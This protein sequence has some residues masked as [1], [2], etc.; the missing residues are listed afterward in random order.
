[1]CECRKDIEA[2]LLARFKEAAP[3]AADHKVDLQGYAFV[4][5]EANALEMRPYMTYKAGA[6]YPLKKGGTK[7]KQQTGNMMFNF[8]PFCGV[9]TVKPSESKEGA[10]HGG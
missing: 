10:P 8:C 4:F 3:E 5:G 9:P 2:R 6:T 1:M 7:W